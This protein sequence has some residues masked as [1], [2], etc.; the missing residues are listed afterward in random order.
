[1]GCNEQLLNLGKN[2]PPGFASF[3]LY[4]FLS[5]LLG[6]LPFTSV[7]SFSYL[8]LTLEVLSASFPVF[9]LVILI[10]FLSVS[11]SLFTT[12]TSLLFK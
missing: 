7:P 6:T 4:C 10:F 8:L 9:P 2:G 5:T 1:M 12:S 3:S 11:K